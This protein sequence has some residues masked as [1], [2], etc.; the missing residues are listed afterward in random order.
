M[1]P[2]NMNHDEINAELELFQMWNPAL[3]IKGKY[4]YRT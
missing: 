2:D 4:K 3:V 1:N